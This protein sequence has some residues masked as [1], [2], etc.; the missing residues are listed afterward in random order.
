MRTQFLDHTTSYVILPIRHTSYYPISILYTTHTS[1]FILQ[2]SYYRTTVSPYYCNNAQTVSLYHRS[3]V[4]PELNKCMCLQNV[5]EK[6]NRSNQTY[7]RCI[8]STFSPKTRYLCDIEVMQYDGYRH[9][10]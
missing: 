6:L 4:S 1:Y 7:T 3:T 10:H 5:S 2:T 9:R 8:A